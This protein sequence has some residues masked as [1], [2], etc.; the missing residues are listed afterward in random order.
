MNPRIRTLLAAL[1]I[2][3]AVPAVAFAKEPSHNAEAK[4]KDDG[5]KKRERPSFPMTGEA[6]T[7]HVEKRL[8]KHEERMEA[9]LSNS[10]MTDE[11]KAAVRKQFADTAAKVRAATKK[12]AADDKV[13]KEEAKTVHQAM[14]AGHKKG[15]KKK[16][17]RSKNKGDKKRGNKK[18]A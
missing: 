17:D 13:T 5:K 11:Q 6:F 18:R 14:R 9:R 8:A 15:D 3:L 2:S 16:G 10:K 1:A 7:A 4:K 12:A